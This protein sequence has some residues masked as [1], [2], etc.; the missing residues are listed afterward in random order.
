M[1]RFRAIIFFFGFSPPTTSQKNPHHGAYYPNVEH[2]T[3]A[4]YV[5]PSLQ[6]RPP[7][8][9]YSTLLCPLTKSIVRQ[10][11]VQGKAKPTAEDNVE[12]KEQAGQEQRHDPEVEGGKSEQKQPTTALSNTSTKKINGT[13]RR[14]N[15]TA[16]KGMKIVSLIKC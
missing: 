5:I 11:Q 16:R 6:Y 8:A 9:K 7:F 10:S 15:L 13:M 14:S 4:T 1:A 12:S 3:R 2:A